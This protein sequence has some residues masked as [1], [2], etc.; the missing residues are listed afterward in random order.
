MSYK[1]IVVVAGPFC[2][3]FD[4]EDKRR[5]AEAAFESAQI[6]IQHV[7]EVAHNFTG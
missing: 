3:E 4:C 7:C 1:Q 6:P 2:K 5:L